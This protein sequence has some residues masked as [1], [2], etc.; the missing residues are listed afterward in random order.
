MLFGCCEQ[1]GLAVRCNQGREVSLRRGYKIPL[2]IGCEFTSSADG[3]DGEYENQFPLPICR[4]SANTEANQER[5]RTAQLRNRDK[6]RTR[7]LPSREPAVSGPLQPRPAPK[8]P[9]QHGV[10]G[11]QQPSRVKVSDNTDKMA[12][13]E[14]FEPSVLFGE[15][16]ANP[17]ELAPC[18]L[19]FFV[20]GADISL[21]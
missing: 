4:T 20:P 10:S 3:Q 21:D 11:D 19:M 13:R 12:E 1:C 8:T 7:P 2:R 18:G 5:K 6:H 16:E 9:R 15:S 17:G 14:G